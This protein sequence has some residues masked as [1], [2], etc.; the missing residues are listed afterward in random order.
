MKVINENGYQTDVWQPLPKNMEWFKL[1]E[2]F[3][4][5]MAQP[6]IMMNISRLGN[7]SLYDYVLTEDWN[8]W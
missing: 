5:Y 4:N 6:S 2:F 3:H 8:Y 1:N 7:A